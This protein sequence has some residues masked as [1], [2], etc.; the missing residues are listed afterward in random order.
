MTPT[1][2]PSARG[3]FADVTVVTA[4]LPA[5]A[6][7]LKLAVR[8]VEHQT[9]QPVA[10][11]IAQHRF[12]VWV[13]F[14]ERI[15]R[16]MNMARRAVTTEWVAFLDDDNQ[17]L[18]DHVRLAEQHFHRA[19]VVYSPCTPMACHDGSGST[20]MFN[21]IDVNAEPNFVGR[22]SVENLIDTNCFIRRAM[23]DELGWFTESWGHYGISELGCISPDHDLFYRLALWG[24][25]F[26]HQPVPTWVY[27][28]HAD[29]QSSK[30]RKLRAT[31]HGLRS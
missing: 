23:L 15:A 5:R 9:R 6:E 2:S 8:S 3:T 20:F 11:I 10:H 25:R 27:N 18:P 24:A 16:T 12:E 17:W 22:Q 30:Q 31:A 13:N 7:L 1:S 14:R 21:A 26:V 29:F 4:S 19:D 28:Q